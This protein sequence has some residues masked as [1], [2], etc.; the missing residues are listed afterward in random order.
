MK[1]DMFPYPLHL[2]VMAL[3][4]IFAVILHFV[5]PKMYLRIMPRY[6]P[7]P[8]QLVFWSG[9]AEVAL[10][11]GLCFFETKN[12]SCYGIIAMLAVFL[13]V[14]F[15]MLSGP[16]AGAGIPKWILVLRLPLQFLLMYWAFTYLWI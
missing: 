13:I 14:H 3:L 2:F 6:L 8:K 10:G 5:K 12:I 1:I 16:K 7:F 11:I 15:H 4:Y 9:I